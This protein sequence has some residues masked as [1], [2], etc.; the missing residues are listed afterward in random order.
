MTNNNKNDC[1]GR[2]RFLVSTTFTRARVLSLSISPVVYVPFWLLT[3]CGQPED[4]DDDGPSLSRAEKSARAVILSLCAISIR[5][6]DVV[7][8]VVFGSR[9]PSTRFPFEFITHSY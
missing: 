4:D 9:F 1:E 2:S 3:F 5:I 8:N 7:E 6:S